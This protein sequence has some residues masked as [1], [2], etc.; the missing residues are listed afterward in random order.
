MEEFQ[1]RMMYS[2]KFYPPMFPYMPAF[3]DYSFMEAPGMMPQ[4][5]GIQ[6][7]NGPQGSAMDMGK[8]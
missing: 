1:K 3:G 7:N 8:Q 6:A 4:M 2:S 5:P